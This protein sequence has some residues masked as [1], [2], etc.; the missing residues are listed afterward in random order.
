MVDQG[1]A[2]LVEESALV[3][4]RLDL[5]ALDQMAEARIAITAITPISSIRLKPAVTRLR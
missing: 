5:D 1:I 3:L 2:D 4:G